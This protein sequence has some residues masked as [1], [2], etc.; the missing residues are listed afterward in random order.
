MQAVRTFSDYIHMVVG[1]FEKCARVV[2]NR[3]EIVR[4]LNLILDFKREIQDLEEGKTYKYLAIAESENI[5][6]QRVTERL[7]KK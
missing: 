3:G 5:Q 6:H 4:S 1:L 2:L 7:K